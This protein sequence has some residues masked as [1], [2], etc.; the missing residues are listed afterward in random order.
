MLLNYFIDNINTYYHLVNNNI[1]D[2]FKN[3]NLNDSPHIN[4]YG[5]N[6]SLKNFYLY[7]II[8]ILTK[9][10]F[11]INLLKLHKYSINVNNNNIDFNVKIYPSFQELNLTYKSNYDK[12]IIT[13]Y[14]VN[15][16]KN[17]NYMYSKH[18]IVLKDF[19]KLN[20]G[21]YM[22][23][24]RIMEIYNKNVLFICISTNL[25]K[26]PDA[27]SS[28]LLNI[29]CP[30]LDKKVI[31]KCIT[32]LLDNLKINY[33]KKTDINKLI[34][35]CD[36]DFN[37]ILLKLDTD[38]YINLN[39]YSNV[40]TINNQI[41]DDIIEK[42]SKITDINK[43]PVKYK[44]IL[45]DK[46]KNHLNYIKKTKNINL[47]LIKNRDFIYKLSHLNYCT[48][49]ILEKFLIILMKY[50]SN[51]IDLDK[52]IKLTSETDSNI[53]KSSRDIYHYEKYLLNI[54]IMFQSQ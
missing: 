11:K 54:Y 30:I 40:K 27:V 4:L 13:K 52:I 8:N 45:K 20:F 9:D 19:D 35:N 39:N 22:S 10:N 53:I 17:C 18:I 47:V 26:I 46:I 38:N 42:F 28:R 29:R 5:H 37:K 31:S 34:K 21:A 6:S 3:L 15:I 43:D 14:I 49:E 7:H 36:N 41:T 50:Y 32:T 44:D 25:S 24:R 48:Q 12:H 16:I 2:N 51:N 1:I 23:L 33:Y